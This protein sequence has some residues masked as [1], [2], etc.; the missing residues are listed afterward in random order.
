VFGRLK[1]HILLV[2]LI[3]AAALV[4]TPPLSMAKNL[5]TTCNIFQQKGPAKHGHCSNGQT[6]SKIQDKAFETAI[7][8]IGLELATAFYLAASGGPSFFIDSLAEFAH[9]TPLRC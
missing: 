7:C 9:P 6:F 1:P 3:A 2:L 8:P 5:P 4:I